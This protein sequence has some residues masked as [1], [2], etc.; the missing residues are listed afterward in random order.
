[1][2][3]RGNIL[4]KPGRSGGVRWPGP[5]GSADRS[6]SAPDRTPSPPSPEWARLHWPQSCLILFQSDILEEEEMS[7]DRQGVAVAAKVTVYFSP[8]QQMACI[9]C[10][11]CGKT[12]LFPFSVTKV[13][14]S[15]YP[16]RIIIVAHHLIGPPGERCAGFDAARD[17][18]LIGSEAEDHIKLVEVDSGCNACS[19]PTCLIPWSQG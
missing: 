16:S 19:L 8:D 17:R 11:L 18:E 4:Y 13:N 2:L 12:S 3:A 1:M 5:V 9:H 15:T 10:H 7:P 6:D 14:G